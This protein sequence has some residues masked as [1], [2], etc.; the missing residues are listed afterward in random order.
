V[1]VFTWQKIEHFFIQSPP[2]QIPNGK[3]S[4]SLLPSSGRS[5][6]RSYR[7]FNR[8]L[9]FLANG[10]H[11]QSRIEIFPIWQVLANKN[12]SGF[13]T[14]DQH[15]ASTRQYIEIYEKLLQHGVFEPKG[16]GFN[17]PNVRIPHLNKLARVTMG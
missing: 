8:R 12:E 16:D 11:A 10:C 15:R 7:E 4:R 6:T 2:I 13:A 5:S 17:M 9:A 3:I 1:I 14:V